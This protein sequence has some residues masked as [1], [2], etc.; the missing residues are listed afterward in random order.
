[1][2]SGLKSISEENQS[3]LHNPRAAAVTAALGGRAIVLVGLMGSGKSAIGR[4]LAQGLGLE[5]VDSDAEVERAADMTIAE[6]FARYGEPYFRDGE[7]RVMARLLSGGPR[8]IATGGG[9]FMSEETRARIKE[10]G[11]SVWLK[12]DLDVLWRRV[13]KRGHRPLLHNADPEGVL[14]TLM[15]ER[16][17][18][19]AQADIAIISQD[20]PHD[21]VVEELL[22]ALQNYLDAECAEVAGVSD[23]Q[24]MPAIFEKVNVAL[25]R[26]SYDIWIGEAIL[27]QIAA[28]AARLAPGASLAIVTDANVARAHLPTIEAALSAAGIR[29]ESIVVAPGEE[30]KSYATFESVCD[31]IIAGHFERGDLVVALGGGVVGD[32]AGFAAASVRRGMPF[33]QVPTTLLAQVDS[34]VGGK[35][36]INSTHGKNLVGAFHQPRLVLIDTQVLKTLPLREF[37]AGYAEVVKYGLINDYAFFEWLEAHWRGV[38]AGG[39]DQVQAIAKSCAAKAAI[40][41]ADEHEAGER[42]LLNLGHTFAHAFERIVHYDNRRLVHG[43]AVAIG[44]ACAFRFSAQRGLTS[45]AQAARVAEHLRR[46]GLPTAI[47]DIPDWDA[48]AATILDA[49]LQ[50]KKVQRGVLTFILAHGIGQSFIARDIAAADVR[51]FLADELKT[52]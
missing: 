49:M 2:S 29:H 4:R 46:V 35:T 12:A 50:D 7:R 1:M 8:V 21:A 48:D 6:I 36:G 51:A 47:R 5:F 9:A 13:R 38:F 45:L 19:Y 43:E 27:L 40:V 39:P 11:I 25:G 16:Y 52:Q 26:R 42:A 32:L 44:L 34:S 22:A 31:A 10:N 33:I 37:R 15:E 28:Q 30:S 3:V 18:I 20:G 23:I 17:P 24:E 41:T 14:K